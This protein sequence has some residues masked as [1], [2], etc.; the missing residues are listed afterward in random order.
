MLLVLRS[1]LELR[2]LSCVVWFRYNC[3]L[4]STH[5]VACGSFRVKLFEMGVY[6]DGCARFSDTQLIH[7]FSACPFDEE[8][9]NSSLL[10]LLPVTEF[11]L[12]QK[13]SG[14][15]ESRPE[16]LVTKTERLLYKLWQD[17]GTSVWEPNFYTWC[18]WE[19]EVEQEPCFIRPQVRSAT[20]ALTQFFY[21]NR[22][23]KDVKQRHHTRASLHKLHLQ[24]IPEIQGQSSGE[25]QFFGG[26]GGLGW[27]FL[28]VWKKL[29]K[30]HMAR[31]CVCQRPGWT[32]T[33]QSPRRHS[34]NI[35]GWN[36][37]NKVNLGGAA[38]NVHMPAS[39]GL[40]VL[41]A[42]T[43]IFGK[44]WSRVLGVFFGLFFWW[45]FGPLWQTL[46][47]SSPATCWVQLPGR[48]CVNGWINS[49]C[50]LVLLS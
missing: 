9:N 11:W 20:C 48:V 38:G 36:S 35:H 7:K 1:Q 40:L 49:S 42:N 44:R 14:R 23:E 39:A 41:T 29:N 19:V 37:Q 21:S 2:R 24:H 50:V 13:G 28:F 17:K 25:K 15:W 4:L 16:T 5:S 22:A 27:L 18:T 45:T 30:N 43:V 33:A 46:C 3:S 6:K 8:D 12:L 32:H 10:R 31:K 47:S 26:G 34:P